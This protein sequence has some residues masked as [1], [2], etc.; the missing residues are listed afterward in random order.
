M[1]TLKFLLFLFLLS[2][3]A[4]AQTKVFNEVAEDISSQLQIIRQDGNLVGYL[5]FTQLEKA[6]ADSFNYR[7][8]IMDENLNDIGSVNFKEEKLILKAVSFEQDVIC[9]VYV[10]SNYLGKEF[11]NN[12]EFRREKDN[13]KTELFAQFVNL[14]GSILGK[15]TTKMDVAPDAQQAANSNRKVVGNG[16][17]KQ[18]IQLRN[19]TGKGFACF[20][21]DDSKNNLL[22][23]NTNGKLT[24][25]K[26]VKEDATD[27]AMLTSG[28]EV[29]LLVKKKDQM[30]EGGFEIVSY[31]T[32]DSVTYPKFILKDRK[33]NSLKVLAF[34]NDPTTG[35]PYVS[36]LVI[37]PAKGNSYTTGRNLRHG[38]YSGVFSIGLNG[39]KRNDIVPSFSYWADG[40]QGTMIDKNGYYEESRAYADL[41]TSFK[42]FEGNTYFAGS[43]I[44]RRFRAVGVSASIL[45]CWTVIVPALAMGPGTHMYNSQNVLVIKQDPKGKLSLENTLPVAASLS[46]QASAP[47]SSYDQR[48]FYTVTNSD[49]KTNY[50]VF[51]DYKQT[52]IYNVNQKKIS[53][54]IPHK[55]GKSF[56]AVFP[57][58]EGHVM[59][60]EYNAKAKQT[61]LSIEAL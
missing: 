31:N 39:H 58:K 53:R 60:S 15:Y 6:S 35:K 37:D 16:K 18:Q 29:S 9:L 41:G 51:D 50:L 5:V 19:I 10:R 22:I 44:H 47:I 7:L 23:F 30:K 56:T 38:P 11:R 20:Y 2:S 3:V 46:L 12:R 57:A 17:L 25:Q 4:H 40:S 26:I 52:F 21:G 33:G 24:W 61:R 54:T 1:R 8:S 32:A 48:S 14:H 34:D 55:E 27:F 36:G 49:A 13:A 42:D 28:T 43:G 59:V 45:L